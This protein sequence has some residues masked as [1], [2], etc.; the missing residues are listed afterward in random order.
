MGSHSSGHKQLKRGQ[1]T[2]TRA[3]RRCVAAMREMFANVAGH[4]TAS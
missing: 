3:H 4:G 2:A 1:R